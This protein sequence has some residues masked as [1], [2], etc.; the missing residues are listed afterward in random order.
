[1][2]TYKINIPEMRSLFSTFHHVAEF[3]TGGL[4]QDGLSYPS[5][6]L[7]SPHKLTSS[8]STCATVVAPSLLC[9]HTAYLNRLSFNYFVRFLYCSHESI[10]TEIGQIV[11][12][13]FTITFFSYFLDG[14]EYDV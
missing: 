4:P 12:F 6:S 2:G 3:I 5:T 1:M 10:N 9:S 8:C 14:L 7:P 13:F 11:I